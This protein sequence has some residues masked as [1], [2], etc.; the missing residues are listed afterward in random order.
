MLDTSGSMSGDKMTKAISDS[1]ELVNYLLSNNQNRIAI[2]TF[3]NASTIIS[4]FSNNFN[5]IS[6]HISILENHISY[7]TIFPPKY[8]LLTM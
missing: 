8:K 3:D 2:I 4:N 6:L 1:K 5:F 7:I